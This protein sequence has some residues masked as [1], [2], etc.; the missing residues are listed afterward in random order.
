VVGDAGWLVPPADPEALATAIATLLDHPER[1]AAL[2]EAGFQRVQREFTWRRAAQ[3]TVAA[4][5][6][7]LG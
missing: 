7:V 6:E 1:A 4:Y 2:G 3:R 5:R